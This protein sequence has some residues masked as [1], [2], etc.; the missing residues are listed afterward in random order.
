MNWKKDL[1][2][3]RCGNKNIN[4][5]FYERDCGPDT[6]DDDIAYTSYICDKCELWYDGWKDEWLINKDGTNV[7]DWIESE[8]AI[9][10]SEYKK[11]G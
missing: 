5:T 11:E 3:P 8:D 10:Y 4:E 7:E 2:C 9:E 1:V 6:W